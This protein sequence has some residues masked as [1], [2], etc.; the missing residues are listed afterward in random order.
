M[1]NTKANGTCTPTNV[2]D[3]V[4]KSGAMGRSTKVT[5]RLIRLTVEEGLFM[6]M[7]IFMMGIGKM[8]RLMGLESTLTLMVPN[9]KESGS[10]TNNTD[11]AKKNGLMA[12]STKEITNSVKK[13]VS[14]S[15]CGLTDHLTKEIL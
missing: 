8:I 1:P 2:M 9:T 4:T 7:E 11:K 6:Q 14:E 3:V 13:T 5:G 10:T 12:P 15:S